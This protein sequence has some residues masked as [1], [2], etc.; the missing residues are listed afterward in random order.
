MPELVMY[1]EGERHVIACL[2]QSAMNALDLK[3]PFNRVYE[4]M[5]RIEE[6]IFF[7][8]GRRGGGSWKRLSPVTIQRREQQGIYGD[9]ILFATGQL[10]DSLTERSAKWQVKYIGKERMEFGTK[11]PNAWMHQE[12][13]QFPSK[14]NRPGRRIPKRPFIKFLDS[15]F[16]R[17]QSWITKYLTD[18][19]GKE[20]EETQIIALDDIQVS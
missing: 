2:E 1:I 14:G 11:R 3:P 15:D 10:F 12:G 7:S 18:M 20:T 5:M 8:S 16:D 4:D 17:W 13:Y 9:S 19:F 6:I